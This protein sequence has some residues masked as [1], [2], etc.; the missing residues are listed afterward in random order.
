MQEKS[1]RDLNGKHIKRRAMTV[2]PSPAK[3]NLFID[4]Y[5]KKK[6]FSLVANDDDVNEDESNIKNIT[7][8]IYKTMN[9]RESEKIEKGREREM[10]EGG[11][12]SFLQS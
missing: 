5:S 2:F 1:E 7:I 4:D 10:I 8:F 3:K 12:L 9:K 6:F 11:K